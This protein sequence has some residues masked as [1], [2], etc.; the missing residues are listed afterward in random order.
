VHLLTSLRLRIVC[1][2]FLAA[3]VLGWAA[4][5]VYRSSHHTKQIRN[6]VVRIRTEV[7]DLERLLNTLQLAETGQRG[8]LITGDEDYLEPYKLAAS[9][10]DGD[11]ARL[12]EFLPVDEQLRAEFPAL[13][14]HIQTKMEEL[15]ETVQLAGVNEPEAARRIVLSGVGRREME[16]IRDTLSAL[17]MARRAELDSGR[18]RY[19]ASLASTT[20][21]LGAGTAIQFVLLVLVFLFVYRD[22]THRLRSAGEMQRAHS[23]LD[24]ILSTMSDGVFQVNPLGS[25]VYLNPAG[26]K[27]LGFSRREMEGLPFHNLFYEVTPSG[28]YRP[29]AEW[30]IEEVLASGISYVSPPA[31]ED[32]FQRKDGAFVAVEYTAMPLRS[33][34]ET[35]GAVISFRD[36]TERRQHEE[37]LRLITELQEAILRSANVAI[38]SVNASGVITTFNSA[39]ERM[40]QYRAEEVIGEATPYIIHEPGEIARRAEELS[41]ELGVKVEPGMDVFT[42]KAGRFNR[43]DHAEWT[44]VRR[45]GTRFPVSLTITALRDFEGKISGFI[46]I[47]EDITERRAAENAIRES[48]ALLAQALEREKDDARLDFLTKIANR[49]AFY[50]IGLKEAA[51]ARRYRRP[52]TLIYIDLDN[53]KSVN[54]TRGHSVGDQLL[55]EVAVTIRNSVRTTDVAARM[56]GDEFAL[57]LPETDNDAAIVVTRKLQEALLESMRRNRWPVTFSIGVV[58]F[59]VPPESVEEMVK[60]ADEVMYSVKL[61]GKNSIAASNTA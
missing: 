34:K 7:A 19:E 44:Y 46:G 25:L 16:S 52:L 21:L 55:I 10:V 8:Y 40:L 41:Q 6:D 36:V 42:I 49:R 58:S 54:D 31:Q 56:G 2:F 59:A 1:S 60:K 29:A 45:D 48:Q 30:P 24:A 32:W 9:H 15:R 13:S 3:S 20:R 23:R 39:A 37:R 33:E 27:I 61:K 18:Q 4:F 35:T 11:L 28:Q 43:P 50:E 12:K 57:L 51:R 14:T 38:I 47:A 17:L 53:F 5:L 22:S 26:E